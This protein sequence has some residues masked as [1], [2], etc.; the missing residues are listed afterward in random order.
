MFPEQ[1]APSQARDPEPTQTA[2]PAP[3]QMVDV[4]QPRRPTPRWVFVVP[5]VVAGILVVAILTRTLRNRQQASSAGLGRRAPPTASASP[6]P[7]VTRATSAATRQVFLS[8]AS[9]DR[10]S[11]AALAGA[12]SQLGVSVWWDRTIPAGKL[13]D[14]VIEAALRS[15]TCVVVLWS[16]ASIVSEWVKTEAAEGAARRILVPALI[17]SVTIPLEFR[18]IQAANLTDWNSSISHAGFRDLAS[19]VAS[20]TSSDATSLGSEPRA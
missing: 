16:R 2:E 11:A 8:Y 4:T 17:E 12:L 14:E 7:E 9:A 18:R 15:S 13:Y 10:S 3:G 19:S 1:P 6:S 5:F 20:L